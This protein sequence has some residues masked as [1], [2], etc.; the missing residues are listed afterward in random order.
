MP[1]VEIAELDITPEAEE[2][3]WRH[4][5]SAN[6]VEA[7]ITGVYV[8]VRNR[9]QRAASHLLIGEDAQG[10]CLT[11][12]IRRT[13]EPYVWQPISAWPCKKDEAAKLYRRQHAR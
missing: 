5:I 8:V 12:P 2:H 9:G 13:A 11:V 4:R 10:R 3:M 7:I 1:P 6:R